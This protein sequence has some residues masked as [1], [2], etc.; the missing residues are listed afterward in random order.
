ML[1]HVIMDYNC[2]FVK[3]T[4]LCRYCHFTPFA[5]KFSKSA[6]GNDTTNAQKPIVN[7]PQQIIRV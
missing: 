3:K 6:L 2:S 4:E 5:L 1:E 7:L